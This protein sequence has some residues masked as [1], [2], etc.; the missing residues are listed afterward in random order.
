LDRPFQAAIDSIVNLSLGV[1]EL[2]KTLGRVLQY[3]FAAPI[4]LHSHCSFR[5]LLNASGKCR[6]DVS[7]LIIACVVL[8]LRAKVRAT[9]AHMAAYREGIRTMA[10]QRTY[11]ATFESNQEKPLRSIKLFAEYFSDANLRLTAIHDVDKDHFGIDIIVEWLRKRSDKPERILGFVR[12][13]YVPMTSDDP[14]SDFLVFDPKAE[15]D[16]QTRK[17]PIKSIDSLANAELK[18]LALLLSDWETAYCGA[19]EVWEAMKEGKDFNVL[20]LFG[21]LELAFASFLRDSLELFNHEGEDD[22]PQSVM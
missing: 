10:E 1:D 22:S 14:D 11:F 19:K 5:H 6:R 16:D 18:R 21:V 9:A 12:W 2:D 20:E 7:Y 13:D 4:T 8:L 17:S 15:G 3:F